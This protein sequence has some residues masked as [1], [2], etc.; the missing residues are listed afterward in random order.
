MISPGSP[1]D[2]D[3][4]GASC[5]RY[6]SKRDPWLVV[7]LLATAAV[8]LVAAGTLAG[9]RAPLPLKIVLLPICVAAAVFVL[10]CLL[11]TCYEFKGDHLVVRCG[12]LRWNVPLAS[13]RE[14]NPV[15]NYVSSAALSS[16][17]LE[18]KVSGSSGALY[19]S[20]A[21]RDAFMQTLSGLCPQLRRKGDRLVAA[22]GL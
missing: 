4:H 6:A 9:P 16:D 12:P 14:V 13:I 3:G 7:T 21:N 10:W 8:L 20:P 15:R 5:R 22:D 11:S 19:V 2:F 18:L 1:T 17:R